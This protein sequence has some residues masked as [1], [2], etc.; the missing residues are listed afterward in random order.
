MIEE[1]DL[2][3]SGEIDLDEFLQ[4]MEGGNTLPDGITGKGIRKQ[5]YTKQGIR[6]Q[7]IRSK[8]Y[9]TTQLLWP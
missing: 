9:L 4:M 2:D 5:R 8:V 3:G 7:S 1:V 6:N